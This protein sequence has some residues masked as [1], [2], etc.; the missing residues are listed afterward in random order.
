MI[1]RS[2]SKA[3]RL[4]GWVFMPEAGW[5]VGYVYEDEKGRFR[6]GEYIHTSQV[7][8]DPKTFKKGIDVKTKYSVYEL[9][10]PSDHPLAQ[11]RAE[12]MLQDFMRG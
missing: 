7:K 11:F 4:E 12:A 2:R 8:Q 6:D 9:G 1:Y 10:E 3:M 5:L